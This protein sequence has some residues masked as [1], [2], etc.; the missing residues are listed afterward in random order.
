[1]PELYHIMQAVSIVFDRSVWYICMDTVL[2]S[3]LH[4]SSRSFFRKEGGSM[5]LNVHRMP[6]HVLAGLI[7]CVFVLCLVP[8]LYL[9]RYDV[10]CADDYIYGT[11]A[12]LALVHGGSLNDAIVAALEHTAAIYHTWQ[13]SG[14]EAIR[15]FFSC[16]CNRQFFR[17]GSIF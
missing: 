13:G 8:L 4:N 5:Q 9:A 11:A 12:H 16:A 15:L 10:P 14:R 3:S 1:M 17:K 6:S 7:L 2:F